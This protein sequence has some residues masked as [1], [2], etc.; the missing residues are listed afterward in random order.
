MS[1]LGTSA[2]TLP[3]DERRYGTGFRS[4]QLVSPARNPAATPVR[5]PIR[6]AWGA[7][8]VF[9]RDVQRV[10]PNVTCLTLDGH[11][12]PTLENDIG[13]EVEPPRY[14]AIP[15]RVLE[16]IEPADER[17]EIM[18]G[19]LRQASDLVV[20][21]KAL[22]Q[23]LRHNRGETPVIGEGPPTSRG[24]Y[25]STY[26]EDPPSYP[27]SSGIS[28][29]SP[30]HLAP[31]PPSYPTTTASSSSSSVLQPPSYPTTRTPSSS[32]SSAV[33]T[34]EVDDSASSSD[35]MTRP[36]VPTNGSV[37]ASMTPEP[38]SYAP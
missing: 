8:V 27:S 3:A 20:Q 9:L 22:S 2:S 30:S 23:E 7:D 26:T 16:A 19:L 5:I 14:G 29:S 11:I 15:G 32:I 36:S 38:P 21:L 4:Y 24:A 25:S 37:G 34:R 10:L 31:P 13:E 1:Y 17:T 33:T 12:L 6:H 18:R 35:T 28:G